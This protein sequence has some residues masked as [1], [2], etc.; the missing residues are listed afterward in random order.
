MGY[1]INTIHYG[2]ILF[3]TFYCLP[4]LS[5][6]KTHHRHWT[7]INACRVSCGCVSNMLLVLSITFYFHYNTWGC[8]CSTGPFK[9]GDWKDISI[10]H[11]II[12]ITSEVSTFPI[13]FIIFR[14]CVPEM[15]VTSYC[16][17]YC[18]YIPGKNGNLFSIVLCSLWGVQIV[19]YVLACR[20]YSFVCTSHR[21]IIIIVQTL[22]EG[23][24]LMKCLSD[25]IFRVCEKD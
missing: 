9:Y 16:V 1:V 25:I 6:R 20:S 3:L 23:I 21:L 7:H 5:L 19:G 24:E 18:T 4:L 13:V 10:V 14:G 15:F 2:R 17:T 12:I 11:A 8:K 22:S